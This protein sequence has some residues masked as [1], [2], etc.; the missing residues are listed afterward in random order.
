M[1]I[2]T[3][4]LIALGLAMDALAVSITC[5]SIIKRL[6][7]NSAFKIAVFFGSFQAL[8]PLVG[9]AA[10]LTFRDYIT[11]FDHWVAF[12]LL[13]LVGGKMIYESFQ[14]ESGKKQIDPLNL[15]ILLVLSIATSIDALAVGLSLSF[16]NVSIILPAIIIGV[17]TLALSFAGVFL[18]NKLAHLLKTRIELL[19]GLILIGI[20]IKILVEHLL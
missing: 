5:G 3:T 9:W 19:G 14:K 1:S 15:S 11:S 2:I 17:I 6:K 7:I 12:G 8:M 20:G 18:G 13:V 16:L 10:G 4:V